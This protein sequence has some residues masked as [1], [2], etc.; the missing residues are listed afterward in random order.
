M[1]T[2]PTGAALGDAYGR[3]SGIGKFAGGFRNF[4]AHGAGAGNPIVD[5][6]LNVVESFV[7]GFAIGHAAGKV[8]DNG[9]EAAAFALGETAD[10]NAIIV[11]AHD[12]LLTASIN[13]TRRTMYGGLMGRRAG[14]VKIVTSDE[15]ATV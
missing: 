14:I 6:F 10:M 8:R 13:R 12:L 11:L 9:D 4:A 15:C 7:L 2:V 3:M 5:R 1:N